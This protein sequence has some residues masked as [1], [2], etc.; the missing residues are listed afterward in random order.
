[1]TVDCV[2]GQAKATRSVMAS[3]DGAIDTLMETNDEIISEIDD[4]ITGLK[5]VHNVIQ[6]VSI[7]TSYSW[8]G[9]GVEGCT[10]QELKYLEGIFSPYAVHSTHST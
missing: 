6:K 2:D 4:I 8:G 9:G 1:M 7:G 3:V 10:I 5:S